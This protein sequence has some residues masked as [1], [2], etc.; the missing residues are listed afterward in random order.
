[1]I[2]IRRVIEKLDEYLGHNDY[3]SAEKLLDYWIDEALNSGDGR[4]ELTLL[5]EQ[6]GLYRK[7]HVEE[8][9]LE[10][11]GKA[12]ELAENEQFGDTVRATTYINAA[13]AYK[14][15][16]MADTAYPLYRQA[17]ALYK[18]ELEAYDPRMAG[19][20]NNMALTVAELG[21]YEQARELYMK[22]LDIM[23]T[24]ENGEIEMAVTYCNLADLVYMEGTSE[25]NGHDHTYDKEDKENLIL[26]Y[27]QKADIMLESVKD[28]DTHYAFFCD[29]CASAF[30]FHGM[31]MT[32]K[33][34]RE[35]AEKTVKNH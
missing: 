19:L 8:K 27:L 30:E 11:C 34:Y 23:S 10:V 26:S 7:Q 2:E 16:G 1:M 29:K 14:E 32:A 28:R 17:E 33:K 31:F 18:V 13:T 21:E 25:Q 4:S 15:F 20:Y 22:A 12:L 3:A 6:I 24:R 9:C 5:N 35:R